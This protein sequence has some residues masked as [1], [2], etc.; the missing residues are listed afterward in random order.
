[1]SPRSEE[2]LA[3]ARARL[4]V[5]RTV[6]DRDSFSVAVSVAYYAALYAARAA[7]SEKDL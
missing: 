7:L 3:E 5:T 6:L 1:M 4:A 2:F